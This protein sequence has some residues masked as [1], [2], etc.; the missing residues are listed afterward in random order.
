MHWDTDQGLSQCVLLV[1]FAL[2][3]FQ[4]LFCGRFCFGQII[5]AVAQQ[6]FL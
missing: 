1:Q 4:C 6:V 2:E 5:V 3:D